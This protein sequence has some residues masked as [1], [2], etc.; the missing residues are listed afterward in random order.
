MST[1]QLEACAERLQPD[2]RRQFLALM[3]EARMLGLQA[4]EVRRRA[5]EVYRAAT[6]LQRRDEGRK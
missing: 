3:A 6:G 1:R 2:E 5:W 4:A